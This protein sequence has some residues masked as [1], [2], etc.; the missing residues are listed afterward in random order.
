M[1]SSEDNK[2][3]GNESRAAQTA[4]SAQDAGAASQPGPAGQYRNTETFLNHTHVVDIHKEKLIVLDGFAF[5][6][7]ELIAYGEISLENFY[8]NPHLNKVDAGSRVNN[9][10]T[11]EAKAILRNHKELKKFALALDEQPGQKLA[12]SGAIKDLSQELQKLLRTY[13]EIGKRHGSRDFHFDDADLE[14]CNEA[15]GKFM[16]YYNSLPAAERSKIDESVIRIPTIYGGTA[17]MKF[18][19]VLEGGFCRC[20]ITEQTYLWYFLQLQDSTVVIPAE[21]VNHSQNA[22]FAFRGRVNPAQFA[23]ETAGPAAAGRAAAGRASTGFRMPNTSAFQTF[24]NAAGLITFLSGLPKT[25]EGNAMFNRTYEVFTATIGLATAHGAQLEG[26]VAMLSSF[27]NTRNAGSGPANTGLGAGAGLASFILRDVFGPEGS[28]FAF[29]FLAPLATQLSPFTALFRGA[30]PQRRQTTA[31][32]AIGPQSE[33]SLL[34]RGFFP[35]PPGRGD[36]EVSSRS[37]TITI[38]SRSAQ[39]GAGAGVGSSANESPEPETQGDSAR[40]FRT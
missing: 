5:D 25:P 2:R 24:F 6:V 10:F 39:G 1:F 3:E 20:I 14:R 38:E 13:L 29:A 21:I 28:F 22:G 34:E 35:F 37:S 36:P 18:K 9:Q 4:T 27:F 15:K 23:S 17:N 32:Q 7:D 30:S 11:D 12:Q 16:E 8:T 26:P 31:I 33:P 40:G 19:D